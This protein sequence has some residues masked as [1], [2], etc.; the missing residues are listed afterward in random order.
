MYFKL[1]PWLWHKVY[2]NGNR[3]NLHIYSWL[4]YIFTLLNYPTR[5]SFQLPEQYRTTYVTPARKHKNKHKKHKHKD[6]VTTGQES[7]LLGEF[8]GRISLFSIPT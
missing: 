3:T 5:F 8:T 6:G 7:T 1:F 4:Y 2:I